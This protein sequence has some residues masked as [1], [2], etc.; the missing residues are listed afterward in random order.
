MTTG[1]HRQPLSSG[2]IRSRTAKLVLWTVLGPVMLCLCAGVGAGIVVVIGDVADMSPGTVNTWA[3]VGAVVSV[4]GGAALIACQ[5][6]V[7]V[8]AAAWLEGSRLTVRR[9]RAR[10]VDLTLAQRIELSA[11]TEVQHARANAVRVPI[12]T[13]YLT[14]TDGS[15]TVQLRL[16]TADGG[17]LP[18]TEM[19]ALADAVSAATCAGAK[20]AE[21]W[22]RAIAADPR[23]LFS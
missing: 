21:N 16:R 12:R 1:E 13:P 14:V 5:I 20:D 2:P 6:V 19:R 7:L 4:L 11:H 23:S 15:T 3:A 17:L 8:R 9:M 22:L 18:S 10:T